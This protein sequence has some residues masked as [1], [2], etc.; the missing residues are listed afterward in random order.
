[1]TQRH[2]IC[3]MRPFGLLFAIALCLAAQMPTQVLAHGEEIEVGEGVKG[4][5]SLTAAQA[6]A[7]GLTLASA[8]FRPLAD[9]LVLNGEIQ[10]LVDR[11][12]Q[13][14]TRISGQVSALYVQLG[15]RVRA[16]QRLARIQARLVGDPPPSVDVSSPKAGIVDAVN[17]SVGQSVEPASALF[18]ISDRSQVNMVARVY[19]ED[20]GKVSLGQEVHIRT[21]SYP[22]KVFNG[23]V[24]LI[25]PGLD[26][27]SRTA[28]VWVRLANPDGILKPNLFAKAA[29]VLKH[30]PAALAIP[31][32]AIMEANGEKMV[33]VKQGKEFNRVE[34]TTGL[35]DDE[36]SE[37]TDGLVP[38]DEVVTQ[39]TRELYTLWLTGGGKKKAPKTEGQG[40]SGN[41]PTGKQ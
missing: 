2:V 11:Q 37:V 10:L 25:G 22:D 17:I 40:T 31:N 39:G 38:G 19:E 41:K 4:P 26:A 36:F 28:V 35:A 15:D 5:V 13:V 21:L 20:L 7:I 1:M 6:K 32:V 29:V 34:I 12:A 14:S 8:D 23:K 18:E 3:P 30:N 24:T 9:L 27:A 16:G 33:F